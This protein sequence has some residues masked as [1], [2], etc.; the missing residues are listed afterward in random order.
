M[1]K[2]LLNQHSIT[3]LGQ[4]KSII[5]FL[6]INCVEKVEV[7]TGQLA[8]KFSPGLINKSASY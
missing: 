7:L 3:N 6:W 8:T 5:K 1:S 2:T 4:N